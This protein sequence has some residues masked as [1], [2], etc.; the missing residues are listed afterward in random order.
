M[1]IVIVGA[2]Q[3]GTQLARHL[4]QEKHDVSIIEANPERARHASNHMDCM[5]VQDEGNSL[6]ALED[7]GIAKA[8]A[9]VCVTD[10][11]EMNMIICG[12]AESRYP[13]L[14]KI[15]RVRND[16]YVRLNKPVEGSFQ[17]P[18]ILGI[19]R[20]IHP[21]VEASRW[22]LNAIEHGA[23]GDIISFAGT[24]YE[25]ASI[26]V[27]PLSPFDGL[28]MM[29][30][31]DLI[32]GESLVTL[33]ERGRS[34]TTNNNTNKSTDN[35]LTESSFTAS[36]LPTGA[37]VLAAGDR[38]H[39]LAKEGDMDRIFRLAGRTEKP[40]RK[41]GIIGG[42][43]IGNLIALGLLENPRKK[44][45][46][47]FSL[48]KNFISRQ[49]NRV[50]IIEPDY[51]LCK[52]LAARFPEALILNEDVSD[53]NFIAE[54]HVDD[55]DLIVTATDHQEFNIITA[56]YLK[57]RGVSRTI[58]LVTSPGYAPIARQLGVDVVVPMKSVVVDSILSHLMGRAVTRVHRLGDGSINILELET[59]ADAPV[60]DKPLKDCSLP[61][62]TLVMLVN[63]KELSFIPQGN[64]LIN[65]GDRI[66]LIA[67][68]GNEAEIGRLFNASA[69][70]TQSVEAGPE[71]T[72][73]KTNAAR[74]S[75]MNSN[76]VPGNS[77]T[78]QERP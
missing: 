47:P 33:V 7:A 18:R 75:A 1:R 55:L 56:V 51:N 41:I 72:P 6:R 17:D 54:E 48:L 52:E 37:T 4:I 53:E 20:F 67:K 19:D 64:H 10:S 32:P 76:T 35:S 73:H 45:R 74:P 23:L 42:G 66:V 62:G 70:E 31:R 63:R 43:R 2:G 12:L 57:S 26:D 13:F 28:S 49:K 34:N 44:D 11:D 3:V 61:P 50:M 30:Y 46:S 59:G 65:A 69:G 24:N 25:L 38:V 27:R 8:N 40:L 22:V 36:I 21:D 68:K 58:A 78:A 39:I 9:L 5:V 29:K 71:T 14:L 15:A 60:A 16:D 77:N